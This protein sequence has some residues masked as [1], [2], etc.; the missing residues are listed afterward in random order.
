MQKKQILFVSLSNIGDAIMTTPVL[1][2]LHQKFPDSEID[3][4]GDQRSSE[5]FLNCPYRGEIIHKNKH[6]FLRGGPSLIK[7]LRSRRFDLVVD[8]RTDG[9]A[10]LLR[11]RKRMTRW[12][13]RPYGPHAVEQHMGV[14][15][16]LHC[17]LAIPNCHVWTSNTEDDFATMV[18]G[19]YSGKRLLC[20]GPGANW[21]GKIW[22]DR[23]YLKLIS[24]MEN[25]FDAV[26]L[27]G[28]K[29]DRDISARIAGKSV[30]PAID[31][32]GKTSLLQ[33]AAVIKQSALFIG[34]DSGLGHLASGVNI[35]TITVFGIGNPER[36]RP[37]G[38]KAMWLVGENQEIEKITVEQVAEC[39]GNYLAGEGAVKK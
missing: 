10:W 12:Q 20:L 1:Q 23:N 15:Y 18:L 14:I 5:I 35:A 29:K 39:A 17:D 16:K 34:N 24:R 31:L 3:I 6:L 27:L 19:E 21:P 4:V 33:A 9:L 7:K 8:L 2:A 25:Y 28:D 11:A 30:L 32:C 22:S 13:G 37:W 36:Y 38:D 26:T